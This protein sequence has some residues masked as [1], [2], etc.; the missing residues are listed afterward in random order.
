VGRGSHRWISW[1]EERYGKAGPIVDLFIK[2]SVPIHKHSLWYYLG[3][4]T[5]FFFGIQVVT[6]CLLLLYYRPSAEEAF[7]SV[8]YIMTEVPYGW[9]IRSLHAWSANLMIAFLM[10]HMFSTFFLKAYR[11]PR[12]LTWVSGALLLFLA[13]GFGFTGYLLPWNE[14]AYFATK[15]GTEIAGAVPVIGRFLVRF[16]RGGEEVT[17][18]T[19]T[20]L[21]GFHVTVL[22][23]LMVLVLGFHLA[24]VQL[25]G[26][27]IPPSVERDP[28]SVREM[29]FFPNF[30]LRDMVGWLTAFGLLVALA[31]IRPWELGTKADPLVPAPPGIRP[32]WYFLFMFQA[33]KLVPARILFWEGEAVAVSVFGLA[34]LLWLLVPFLDRRSSEGQPSPIFTA[35]GILVVAFM[36]SMTVLSLF[37]PATE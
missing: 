17:G 6:G 31:A 11:K 13:L 8:R 22:P 29:P 23:A 35:V 24:V 1:L 34:A 20:R 26:M 3:G 18:A 4:M 15:V 25:Q 10:I 30:L 9:L 19:L 14:L 7:E 28:R 37:W 16:L 33:L 2:K 5:L 27:S 21:F 36:L 32:E 12:E